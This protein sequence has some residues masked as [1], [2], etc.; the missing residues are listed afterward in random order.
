MFDNCE[1]G[2]FSISRASM[3]R[4]KPSTTLGKDSIIFS[5][6]YR[7]NC[8]IILLFSR[9]LA[10]FAPYVPQGHTDILRKCFSPAF[11]KSRQFQMQGSVANTP[12]VILIMLSVDLGSFVLHIKRVWSTFVSSLQRWSRTSRR[13]YENGSTLSLYIHHPGS[14]VERQQEYLFQ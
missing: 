4:S 8:K 9:L 7:N 3:R 10:I 1:H 14:G 13:S 12:P 6:C 2:A 11:W 5:Y